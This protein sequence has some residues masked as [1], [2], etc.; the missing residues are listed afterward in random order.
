MTPAFDP[1]T[2]AYEVDVAFDDEGVYVVPTV[3]NPDYRKIRVNTVITTSSTPSRT[4]A[5]DPGGELE[6]SIAVTAQNGVDVLG[7]SSAGAVRRA[8]EDGGAPH[9]AFASPPARS[10]PRSPRTC[11]STPWAHS[12]TR[13]IACKSRRTRWTPRTSR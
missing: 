3:E 4:F 7:A 12:I 13:R 6:M 10:S 2:L 8:R 5:V 1:A 11:S 9:R